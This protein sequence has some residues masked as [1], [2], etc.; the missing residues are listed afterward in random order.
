MLN[1]FHLRKIILTSSLNIFQRVKALFR[2][3]PSWG[4]ALLHH[5]REAAE[6][7]RKHGTDF[8]GQVEYFKH[9]EDLRNG[10]AL[11]E[12]TDLKVPVV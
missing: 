11:E 7:H 6:V 10:A 5:R 8:G 2:P 1:R 4:P 12:L 9:L 3:L